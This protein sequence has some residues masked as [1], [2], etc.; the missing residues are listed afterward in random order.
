M[1]V[2]TGMKPGT[3]V[4]AY[5]D[6]EEVTTHCRSFTIS[7]DD[8]RELSNSLLLSDETGNNYGDALIVDEDGSL[9]GQFLIPK[10]RFRAGSKVFKLIDTN[11]TTSASTQF[12]AVGV[13]EINEGSIA[14]TRFPEIRQ[15]ALSETQNNIVSRLLLNNPATFNP[16]SFGDPMAQTFIIEGEP[17]GVFVKGVDVFF[18]TKSSDKNFTV[19]IR[20]VVN[21]YPGNKIVPFSTKTLNAANITISETA[22]TAT[23]FTFDNPVY[24]KNNTEYAL[25]LLP[26][27][28]STDFQVWV[29]ELGE[30]LLGTNERIA[31]QPYV[32]VLFIPNNNTSWTA[33]EKEDLKFAIKTQAFQSS[34]TV[35]FESMPI[36]YVKLSATGNYT[37]RAGDT[38]Q[39][40]DVDENV[41][42][43]G[44]VQETY[45]EEAKLYITEG[46]LVVGDEFTVS[47][48]T[49]EVDEIVDKVV[50]ALAPNFGI[51]ELAPTTQVA[52]SY[53]I[54]EQPN[55]YF[56][57]I[58]DDFIPFKNG[59]TIEL[60]QTFTLFSHS[61]TT[62]NIATLKVKA[63]LTSSRS[64]LTPVID[65]R[66]MST[67]AIGNDIEN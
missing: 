7:A 20:E 58:V 59:D 26:E 35:I 23:T 53:K 31:Q 13:A 9:V 5:F 1:F 28:N 56:P 24:L 54:L 61:N 45:D 44:V 51:L 37:L 63:V 55:V 40:E 46:S 67:L 29:S 36:D 33:L 39:V 3:A 62:N 12:H 42:C 65:T 43:T 60:P 8:A 16:S 41:T 19:Q 14:S 34:R 2:A 18:R 4:R 10:K 11:E 64:R 17:D 6:G 25:V 15:D 38:F 50:T 21:G 22:T 32:G 66:K 49:F 48:T 52:L 47:G 27:N 30:T 57:S